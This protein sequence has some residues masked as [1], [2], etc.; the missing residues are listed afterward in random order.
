MQE[1]VIKTVHDG[2]DLENYD[3]HVDTV[4]ASRLPSSACVDVHTPD[5]SNTDFYISQIGTVAM[6]SDNLDSLEMSLK[7]NRVGSSSEVEMPSECCAQSLVVGPSVLDV[8]L[9]IEKPPVVEVPSVIEGSEAQSIVTAPLGVEASSVFEDSLIEDLSAVEAPNV[10]ETSSL[11]ESPLVVEVQS[12]KTHKPRPVNLPNETR[13]DE[14]EFLLR[15][16][17]IDQHDLSSYALNHTHTDLF[18]IDRLSSPTISSASV[19]LKQ[20]NTVGKPISV[21]LKKKSNKPPPTSVDGDELSQ[22][23]HSETKMDVDDTIKDHEH[24]SKSDKTERLLETSNSPLYDIEHQVLDTLLGETESEKNQQLDPSKSVKITKSIE[25]EQSMTFSSETESAAKNLSIAMNGSTWTSS[26]KMNVV[27][28]EEKMSE[29]RCLDTNDID[30]GNIKS[31][32]DESTL[33]DTSKQQM[34]KIAEFPNGVLSTPSFELGH[35]E[36]EGQVVSECKTIKAASQIPTKT[37]KDHAEHVKVSNPSRKENNKIKSEN[38]EQCA[39]PSVN[40]ISIDK[41]VT[42]NISKHDDKETKMSRRKQETV[43]NKSENEIITGESRNMTI[44]H[45]KEQIAFTSQ[46]ENNILMN[47]N[48]DKTI[49]NKGKNNIESQSENSQFPSSKVVN[50]TITGHIQS[51]NGANKT[52]TSL[53]QNLNVV[54]GIEDN[55]HT[56]LAQEM[57]QSKYKIR[58][59][60]DSKVGDENTGEVGSVSTELSAVTCSADDTSVKTVYCVKPDSD[61]YHAQFDKKDSV[62]KNSVSG[63]AKKSDSISNNRDPRLKNTGQT[64]I[65]KTH[66]SPRKFNNS[67]L[68]DDSK[69]SKCMAS[70]SP[71]CMASPSPRKFKVKLPSISSP[72]PKKLKVKLPSISCMMQRMPT[73]NMMDE[74][75]MTENTNA[76][77]ISA[78][79]TTNASDKKVPKDVDEN[80]FNMNSK[81]IN[82]EVKVV[83]KMGE[84][85]NVPKSTHTLA[86][87]KRKISLGDYKQ[88]Q[89]RVK[90]DSDEA[91]VSNKKD[92]ILAE[93]SIENVDPEVACSSKINLDHSKEINDINSC[94][95]V[96]TV[97]I[98][99]QSEN[100]KNSSENV[101]ERSLNLNNIVNFLHHKSQNNTDACNVGRSKYALE[102]KAVESL[103]LVKCSNP[104]S[105]IRPDQKVPTTQNISNSTLTK[106]VKFKSAVVEYLDSVSSEKHLRTDEQRMTAYML[107]SKDRNLAQVISSKDIAKHQRRISTSV[108]LTTNSDPPDID[109]SQII[110][111]IVPENLPSNDLLRE[112][113]SRA[114]SCTALS[115]KTLSTASATKLDV[116]PTSMSVNRKQMDTTSALI[117]TPTLFT[118]RRHAEIIKEKQISQ[119]LKD[120]AVLNTKSLSCHVEKSEKSDRTNKSRHP[121]LDKPNTNEPVKLTSSNE[122]TKLTSTNEP[123]KLTSTNERTKLTSTNEHTKLT[124]AN[125]PVKLTSTNERTKLTSTNER[126]KLTSTNEPVKL[127]NANEPVKHTNANE[128]TKLTNT[129]ERTM[130]TSTNELTKLMSTKERTKHTNTNER[131]KLTKI[132]ANNTDGC[133]PASLTKIASIEIMDGVSSSKVSDSRCISLKDP[134][135]PLIA[136][137]SILQLDI[138]NAPKGGFVSNWSDNT[139]LDL[140]TKGSVDR[141][142]CA[143]IEPVNVSIHCRS[144]EISIMLEPKEET[145]LKSD[146]LHKNTLSEYSIEICLDA[147]RSS[148]NDLN[149]SENPKY[150]KNVS[151]RHA[152]ILFGGNVVSSDGTGVRDSSEEFGQ[153]TI[154]EN[155]DDLYNLAMFGEPTSPFN[156]ICSPAVTPHSVQRDPD[157]QTKLYE[158]GLRLENSSVNLSTISASLIVKNL[159][160]E[161]VKTVSSVEN[162]DCTLAKDKR[163]VC[164][165]E[166]L[167]FKSCTPLACKILTNAQCT[168]FDDLSME[169]VIEISVNTEEFDTSDGEIDDTTNDIDDSRIGSRND[170]SKLKIDSRNRSNRRPDRSR[171]SGRRSESP[172]KTTNIRSGHSSRSGSD[173]RG[174]RTNKTSSNSK[175]SVERRRSSERRNN[176]SRKPSNR[177]PRKSSYGLESRSRREARNE[178]GR[179]PSRSPRHSSYSYG[180]R[181]HGS[182]SQ[183]CVRRK[184]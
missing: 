93:M 173:R 61:K 112:I 85:I 159:F 56:T 176:L 54:N 170:E 121:S 91:N 21:N 86:T 6:S 125:E 62:I 152:V 109:S 135:L 118:M 87:G 164:S 175:V 99:M 53:I 105:K 8:P 76:A 183:S 158:C 117:N 110:A 174:S 140:T 30:T 31:G 166:D 97:S 45:S 124:N 50:K 96:T 24:V 83:R 84:I 43:R 160:D 9:L 165:E 94:I 101:T 67:S 39:N 2:A 127:T 64:T 142:S 138:A 113:L 75:L 72:S 153:S 13:I 32:I 12:L 143:V 80:N 7:A 171:S 16:T 58:K 172:D 146:E 119:K 79:D 108:H 65:K 103:K 181:R 36:S 20:A 26:I 184:R 114:L 82:K 167:S 156:E 29:T 88:K 104:D 60:S 70:P 33:V 41:K 49:T 128:P 179:A 129:Q 69:S 81:C 4:H 145:H 40:V 52:A 123:V 136:E 137:S 3:M 78:V 92:Q 25:H 107:K 17:S 169:N 77:D 44:A 37:N 68:S 98:A 55:L 23:Q 157:G 10:I 144:S 22:E 57:S 42:R 51:S 34:L 126:T 139:P 11:V 95:N 63:R 178:H 177:T 163:D 66:R 148:R 149:I 90:L 1:E 180:S 155:H 15:Q 130:F 102:Q 59:K 71:K 48:N 14:N 182:I 150:G 18:S 27:D 115:S 74:K 111:G 47:T 134:L 141:S 89:K 133:S 19:E 5:I 161:N 106:I 35:S 132:A 46:N 151:N 38:M 120:D 73:H 131:T 116:N 162:Q 154:D 122:H 28:V 147:N 100:E 168:S